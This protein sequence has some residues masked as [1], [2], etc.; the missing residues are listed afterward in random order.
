MLIYRVHSSR[1]ERIWD[2]AQLNRLDMYRKRFT[3]AGHS[4]I[5]FVIEVP[6][7]KIMTRLMLEYSEYLELV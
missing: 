5:Q 2:F 1:V 4:H 3:M 6:D 7:S